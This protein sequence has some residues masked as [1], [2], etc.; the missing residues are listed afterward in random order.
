MLARAPD[1]RHEAHT[2]SG[3]HQDVLRHEGTAPGPPAGLPQ[4]DPSPELPKEPWRDG[5]DE[6][7]ARDHESQHDPSRRRRNRP[8]GTQQELGEH[9][10]R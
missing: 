2:V 7:E 8:A 6:D 4:A 1:V 3:R 9:L 10:C 5:Q